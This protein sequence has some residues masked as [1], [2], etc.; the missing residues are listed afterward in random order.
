MVR[1]RNTTKTKSCIVWLSIIFYFI[2]PMG[3]AEG[4]V[5]CFGDD[6]HILVKPAPIG[7]QCGHSSPEPREKA[8]SIHAA[9]GTDFSSSECTSC[10]DIPLFINI[11]GPCSCPD[12]STVRLIKT[13]AIFT[14]S[15]FQPS[16]A[17]MVVGNSSHK[18]LI[19]D[20]STLDSIR[21]IIL[22]I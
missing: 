6:G 15:F 16:F 1:Y 19:H 2:A 3:V 21:S 8:S 4:F 14:H 9:S 10:I 13:P 12:L 7:N 22:L 18:P 5:L 11:I 20:H 17:N